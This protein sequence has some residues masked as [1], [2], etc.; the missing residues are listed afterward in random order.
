MVGKAGHNQPF[1]QPKVIRRLIG[2]KVKLKVLKYLLN[3]L[4]YFTLNILP[5]SINQ[6]GDVQSSHSVRELRQVGPR[7]HT[8]H[9]ELDDFMAHLI[10]FVLRHEFVLGYVKSITLLQISSAAI[11]TIIRK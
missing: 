8:S 11:N 4:Y 7:H 10:N 6:H 9:F 2:F 1:E 5:N 3:Q